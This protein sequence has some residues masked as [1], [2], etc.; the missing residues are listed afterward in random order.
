MSNNI[1]YCQSATPEPYESTPTPE[2]LTSEVYR[3]F[4]EECAAA[5]EKRV[6]AIGAH[7]DWKAVKAKEAQLA[8]LKLDKEVH[9]EKLRVLKLEEERKVEE[10]RQEDKWIRLEAEKAAKELKEREDAAECKQIEDLEAKEKEKEK[11][12]EDEANKLA[13]VAAGAPSAS[14]GDTEVDPA[15]PK[16]AAIAELRKRRAITE[17]KKRA[18]STESQKCK[19]QS[20]SLVDD[21]GVEGGNASA[22]PLMPKRLK[23][24]PVPQGKDKIFTGNGV[25]YRRCSTVL[26]DFFFLFFRV[27]WKVSGR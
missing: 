17:G 16:T 1:E 6:E 7:K 9:L 8:K 22:G 24:E 11:E 14:K 20:A 25:W 12:K 21:S 13:L 10:K 5:E 3:L 4:T 2:G 15:D 19:V 27:L 23:T 18:C 26:V